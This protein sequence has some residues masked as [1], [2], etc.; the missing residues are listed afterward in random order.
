[1]ALLTPMHTQPSAGRKTLLLLQ[2]RSAKPMLA[3]RVHIKG[4]LPAPS[5]ISN[6]ASQVL[7]MELYM[8]QPEAL[9]LYVLAAC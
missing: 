1:M 5:C 2:V 7:P 8:L 3:P 9:C 4:T 6:H